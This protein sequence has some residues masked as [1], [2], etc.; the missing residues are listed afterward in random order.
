MKFEQ[1]SFCRNHHAS[2]ADRLFRRKS[3]TALRRTRG[4][5]S[6]GVSLPL[7]VRFVCTILLIFGSKLSGLR[8][9]R[10]Q[11]WR[12][13]PAWGMASSAPD[14]T[15][16]HLL[17]VR[18][19]L[20]AAAAQVGPIGVGGFWL[21]LEVRWRAVT[22]CARIRRLPALGCGRKNLLQ[23][24]ASRQGS[25]RPFGV[26]SS[27]GTWHCLT[28]GCTGRAAVRWPGAEAAWRAATRAFRYAGAWRLRAGEP[29]IR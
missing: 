1:S 3:A 4:A 19:A 20:W 24:I 25:A 9:R 10:G 14:S 18:S 2:L 28:R 12:R 5:R 7:V 29:Q 17:E 21:P 6:T 27:R 11:L 22:D 13:Q 16:M 8:R 26:L 15:S 23:H